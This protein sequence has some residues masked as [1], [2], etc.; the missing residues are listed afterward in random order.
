MEWGSGRVSKEEKLNAARNA[1]ISYLAGTKDND[2]DPW[3]ELVRLISDS[4]Q[5]EVFTEFKSLLDS[6]R[7]VNDKKKLGIPLLHLTIIY[8][9][10][11]YIEFLYQG[12]RSKLDFNLC[13]DVAGYTPLMWCFLLERTDCCTELL[14]WSTEI[15]FHKVSKEEKLSAWDMVAKYSDF[16]MFLEQNNMLQYQD[17]PTFQEKLTTENDNSSSALDQNALRNIDLH[18]AGLSLASTQNNEDIFASNATESRNDYLFGTEQIDSGINEQFDFTKLLP[19]QYVEFEDY[20]IKQLLDLLESLPK[21]EPHM[22]TYAAALIFQMVRFAEHKKK[23]PQL[24]HTIMSLS[25]ARILAAITTET[26]MTQESADTAFSSG[27]IVSQSYWLGVLTFLYYYLTREEGFFKK[28]PEILQELINTIHSVIIELTLSIYSRLTSII[29]PTILS[30]TTISDVKETLYKRDWN[31]FKKR[32]HHKMMQKQKKQEEELRKQEEETL[33][34]NEDKLQISEALDESN[35]IDDEA[36]DKKKHSKL[37]LFKKKRHSGQLSTSM[38]NDSKLEN[39]SINENTD[40][41]YDTE[42]IKHLYPPSMEEQMKPSPM[43]V[44]QI[45]GALMYVLNLHQI[46]PLFQQQCLSLA[47]QWFSNNLFNQILKDK[48]KKSL[49]RAHAIQIRLNLSTFEAWAK[50]NDS[51]VPKPK[52]IDDFMWERFPYTLVED[53]ANIDLSNPILNNVATVNKVDNSSGL[54]DDLPLIRDTDNSLFYYQSLH[55]ILQIHMEPVFQLLQWLQVATTIDSEDALDSTLDLLSRLT[56]TQLLKAADKYSYE[57]DE[58][59]FNSKLKK[60]LSTMAKASNNKESPYLP[61]R[62][63]SLLVLPTIPEMTDIYARGVDHESY[64]PLLPVSIQDMIYEIHSENAKLRMNASEF[65]DYQNEEQHEQEVD[66]EEA[67]EDSYKENSS[68]N[69]D[70]DL[71]NNNDRFDYQTVD[72]PAVASHWAPKEDFEENPW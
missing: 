36:E 33:Q 3:T 70:N 2:E 46:H 23:Q 15:D 43:K 59:K 37:K 69:E 60:K 19:N 13:D 17:I 18:V 63:V 31:F 38:S 44:V 42:V 45:F 56:P 53:V 16:Y 50:N 30:Y 27:D 41:Y 67:H 72:T 40:L 26:D 22:T 24:V 61:E 20:D 47:I 21:K 34:N 71:D 65:Y 32:K 29:Q 55:R 64:Q 58:S 66:N 52:M 14:T 9:R 68:A 5:G 51:K 25:L 6:V 4:S 39:S 49:S 7:D 10:A 8:D 12:A 57:I 1:V 28:Y 35:D 48:K 62:T 11:S 54:N